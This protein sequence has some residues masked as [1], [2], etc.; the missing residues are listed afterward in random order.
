MLIGYE[1]IEAALSATQDLARTAPTACILLDHRLLS[2][3]GAQRNCSAEP[4]Q[5]K[6]APH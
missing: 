4:Y 2:L 6:L 1:S 5:P 3:V